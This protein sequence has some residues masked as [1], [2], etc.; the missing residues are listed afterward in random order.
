M[1]APSVVALREF[2]QT[3]GRRQRPQRGSCGGWEQCLWWSSKVLGGCYLLLL[4]PSGPTVEWTSQG[5]LD[6]F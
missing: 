4:G 5:L 1:E 3:T 2:Y 6:T